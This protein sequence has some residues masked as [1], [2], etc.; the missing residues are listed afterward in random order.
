MVEQTAKLKS[1]QLKKAFC[2]I[3]I[4]KLKTTKIKFRGP[5]EEV[6]KIATPKNY[7]LYVNLTYMVVCSY[8]YMCLHMCIHDGL[9][10]CGCC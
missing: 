9:R 1:T 8:A 2:P 5:F 3:Q 6:T 10:M 7:R 4:M